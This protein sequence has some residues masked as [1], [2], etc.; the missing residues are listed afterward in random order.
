MRDW[1]KYSLDNECENSL[2]PM[3][4]SF[5]EHAS[6]IGVDQEPKDAY[7]S[8]ESFSEHFISIR[9]MEDCNHTMIFLKSTFQKMIRSYQ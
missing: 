3:D 9:I 4:S 1:Y 5:I 2:K 8:K 7:N 6:A